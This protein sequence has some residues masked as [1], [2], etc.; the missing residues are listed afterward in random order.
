MAAFQVSGS[1]L[2][3]RW[4][5][6]ELC[7]GRVVLAKEIRQLF[8]QAA[9][10]S[11][12]G[13]ACGS[14][15]YNVALTDHGGQDEIAVRGVVGGVDPDAALFSLG[16]DRSIDRAVVC[17]GHADFVAIE[18]AIAIGARFV[19]DAAGSEEIVQGGCQRG[20]E[21]SDVRL[22]GEEALH[23][24]L[25]NVSA[26]NDEAAATGHLDEDGIVSHRDNCKARIRK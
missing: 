8:A 16:S 19:A 5:V 6:E 26:A 13:A 15:H 7:Q 11:G 9:G 24:D 4:R 25:G 12:T 14:S 3:W 17:G 2:I 20:R 1:T 23:L 21:D 18:V 22:G 10:E